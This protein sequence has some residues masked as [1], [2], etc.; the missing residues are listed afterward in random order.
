ML[1][2]LKALER[3]FSGEIRRVFYLWHPTPSGR[4]WWYM[5]ETVKSTRALAPAKC[6]SR[7]QSRSVRGKLGTGEAAALCRALEGSWP[8]G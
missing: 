5:R 4:G 2:S 8:S 7:D 6:K 1:V 3:L